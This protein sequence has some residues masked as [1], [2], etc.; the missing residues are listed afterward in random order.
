MAI[1]GVPVSCD[2]EEK[3]HAAGNPKTREVCRYETAPP[4]EPAHECEPTA[5]QARRDIDRRRNVCKTLMRR[6]VTEVTFNEG[7]ES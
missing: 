2:T 1:L 4:E 7:L 5:E 6:F 3:I